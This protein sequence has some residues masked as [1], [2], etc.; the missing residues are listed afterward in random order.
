MTQNKWEILMRETSGN[1]RIMLVVTA[2]VEVG[3]MVLVLKRNTYKS[4]VW[5]LPHARVETGENVEAAL[6]RTVYGQ[7][8]LII[9]RISH[10]LGAEDAL[11]ADGTTMQ[12]H[13]FSVTVRGGGQNAVRPAGPFD[14]YAWIN[15]ADHPAL[16]PE[17][18]A[19]IVRHF[20]AVRTSEHTALL[21]RE[22]QPTNFGW[23]GGKRLR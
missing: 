12:W 5:E 8:G 18:C 3:G 19:R 6:A 2:V 14:H 9:S 21:G 7:S 23:R 11:R 10:Y 1:S 20:C 13:T 22:P 15:D 16:P 4:G 17:V